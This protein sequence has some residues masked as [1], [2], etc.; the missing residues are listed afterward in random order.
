V[1]AFSDCERYITATPLRYAHT[2]TSGDPVT[3][4]TPVDADWIAEHLG[5]SIHTVRR[6]FRTGSLPGRKVGKSWTTT[7]AALDRWLEGGSGRV[8][9]TPEAGFAPLETK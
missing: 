2:S 9:E 7:R 3:D 8:L 6:H 5:V 1:R 4:N